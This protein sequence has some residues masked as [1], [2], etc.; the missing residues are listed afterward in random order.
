MISFNVSYLTRVL[1]RNHISK[2]NK[3]KVDAH[4]TA[5]ARDAERKFRGFTLLS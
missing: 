1:S 5:R 4:N 2:V 3:A